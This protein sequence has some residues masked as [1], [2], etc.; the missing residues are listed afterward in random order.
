MSAIESAFLSD[1]DYLCIYSAII[2]QVL[3]D[4]QSFL[5]SRDCGYEMQHSLT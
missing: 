3:Y 1:I 5:S 4:N 2:K